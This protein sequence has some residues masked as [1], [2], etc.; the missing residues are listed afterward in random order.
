VGGD[1]VWAYNES[2]ASPVP[3]LNGWKVPWDGPVDSALRLT[4]AP[5]GGRSPSPPAPSSKRAVMPGR[6]SSQQRGRHW[7]DED[8]RRRD[9]QQRAVQDQQRRAVQEQ[10]RRDDERRRREADERRRRE[11]DEEQARKQAEMKKKREEDDIRRKE[12]AAALAVRKVIQKVRVAT[13]ETYDKL[14]TD[15]EEA[16]ATHLEALGSQAEKVSQEA[17]QTLQQATDA[18]QK[19]QMSTRS[20]GDDDA[21]AKPPSSRA[22]RRRNSLTRISQSSAPADWRLGFAA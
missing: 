8:R 17:E 12:Q 13:P 11:R 9:E 14:R 2:K 1:Q 3:P 16:L 15:L 19:I 18:L 4:A 22:I 6:S 5:A 20:V 7:E 10:E 21:P